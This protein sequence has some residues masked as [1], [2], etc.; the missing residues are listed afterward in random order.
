MIR[1]RPTPLHPR[2][3]RND[4]DNQGKLPWA[5]L[6]A[7]LLLPTTLFAAS[8]PATD[9]AAVQDI[10]DDSGGGYEIQGEAYLCTWGKRTELHFVKFDRGTCHDG[11]NAD[12][13]MAGGARFNNLKITDAVTRAQAQQQQILFVEKILRRRAMGQKR[14]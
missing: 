12:G 11:C 4:A 14:Q 8:D 13:A 10:C 3:K 2:Q 9:K 5:L 7:L 6:A 1:Y